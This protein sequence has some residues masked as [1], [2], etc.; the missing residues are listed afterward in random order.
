MQLAKA[1]VTGQSVTSSVAPAHF[2][3]KLLS[4]LTPVVVDTVPPPHKFGDV[5][6]QPHAA[7]KTGEVVEA[8]FWSANPRNNIRRGGTFLEV[9]Y[10]V[11]GSG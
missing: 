8:V 5:I 3:H 4:F 6:Q 10:M 7:Y 11:R 9:Q 2:E 1:L